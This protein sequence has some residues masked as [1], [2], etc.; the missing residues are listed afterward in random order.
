[1]RTVQ[2][3]R[4]LDPNAWGGTEMALQRLFDSL[5][6]Q[7]VNSVV[8]CPRVESMNGH[9]RD[10]IQASGH[11]VRRF[12]AFVPVLGMQERRKRQL[13]S[14][15]GNLMSFDLI[16]SLWNERDVSIVHSH[17]LGRIGAIARTFALK[18]K[19]PFVVTIHGGVLDLPENVKKTFNEPIRDGLEWGKLFGLL[20]RSNRVFQDADAIITCNPKE[21]GL[22]AER[23][24]G[25][26]VIVQPHGVEFEVYE[27]DCREAAYKAFP[28]LRNR[29]VLLSLG[30]VD[31]IKNQEFLVEQAP[32]VFR[33]HPN[34]MMVF[35]GPCTDEPYGEMIT[36]K[37]ADLG[38]QNRILLT[39][40]LPPNDPRLVGLLQIARV[41]T[42]P[43]LSETFGL[44]I[45]E[46]WAAGAPVL[47]SAT[48]GA[49]ALTKHGENGFLFEL[50]KP[51]TF[52]A[53]LEATL[54]DPA[55]AK[56]MAATGRDLALSGYSLNALAGRMRKL[57]T[58]LAEEK[59][60]AT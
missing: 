24:P 28:Q 16:S 32:E 49:K 38:L 52:H 60:C 35:A 8:Y 43:S 42:L 53:G 23:L 11:E 33:K 50:E 26:R 18:R 31:P 48:S 22:W 12:K 3:L 17:T 47:C 54:A 39:G 14:V 59:A 15:G 19:V 51:E 41:L 5:R 20:F 46:A 57:Y 30:R 7:G 9:Q 25:K 58:E 36:R 21:A 37:I 56:A 6:A 29:A 1:M 34:A 10:P 13:I 40:G 2:V 27:K 44:V 45:I 55:N 4:K